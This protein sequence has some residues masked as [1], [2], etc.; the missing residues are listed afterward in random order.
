MKGFWSLLKKKKK[1]NAVI[2][3][4]SGKAWFCANTSVGLFTFGCSFHAC[5]RHDW[6]NQICRVRSCFIWF[7]KQ[8]LNMNSKAKNPTI[9]VWSY[10]TKNI[11]CRLSGSTLF[12]EILWDWF[13]PKAKDLIWVGMQLEATGLQ[14]SRTIRK[15]PWRL[16]WV[17]RALLSGLMAVDDL[18]KIGRTPAATQSPNQSLSLNL[19]YDEDYSN[20]KGFPSGS[21]IKNPPAMQE[22]QETQFYPWNGK[23]PW[24]RKWQHSPVFLPGKPHGQRNLMGYSL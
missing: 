10:I 13:I 8:L 17:C 4:I 6:V 19:H 3:T 18:E 16:G 21:V 14:L 24:I 7:Q 12:K 5:T 11:K 20:L 22:I 9:A 1:K 15:L 23:I 2:L